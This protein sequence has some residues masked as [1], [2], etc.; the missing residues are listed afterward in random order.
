MNAHAA[1]ALQEAVR[2]AAKLGAR[3]AAMHKIADTLGKLQAM[4]RKAFGLD[5]V[6]VYPGTYW[7]AF[8]AGHDVVALQRID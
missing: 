1:A 5:D 4:E 3:V 2:D 8:I 6:T 7:L